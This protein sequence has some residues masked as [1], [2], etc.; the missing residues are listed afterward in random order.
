[1]GKPPRLRTYSSPPAKTP[2]LLSPAIVRLRPRD[3]IEWKTL[4]RWG[5]LPY[6]EI[7]PAG[8]LFRL[9]REQAGFTQQELARRLGCS[10]QAIAQA[11][12]WNSNP[13]V[14]FM[15]RWAA[16]CGQKLEIR[17]G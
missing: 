1:M 5:K 10:Q 17:I 2:P 4:R 3:Y 15:R 12:R 6:W 11:E 8:F 13:S 9:A 7:E 14:D 16:K